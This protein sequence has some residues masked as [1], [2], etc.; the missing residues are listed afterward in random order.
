[1]ARISKTVKGM[2]HRCNTDTEWRITH[3]HVDYRGIVHCLECTRCGM[4]VPE[5][6]W[7]RYQAEGRVVIPV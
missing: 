6:A 1:M 4:L 2:C 3:A 7:R 5:F